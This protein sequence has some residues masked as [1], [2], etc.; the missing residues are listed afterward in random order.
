MVQW[1]QL[2]FAEQQG[3][4]LQLKRYAKK[5]FAVGVVDAAAAGFSMKN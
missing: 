2:L 5:Q 3:A 4:L 1:E